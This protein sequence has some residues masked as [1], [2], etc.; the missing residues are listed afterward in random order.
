MKFEE[1]VTDEPPSLMI[2]NM[3]GNFQCSLWAC[4]TSGKIFT[5]FATPG[6]FQKFSNSEVSLERKFNKRPYYVLIS[7]QYSYINMRK[8]LVRLFLHKW[9]H[10]K[11]TP[12][13]TTFISIRD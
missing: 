4:A 5:R 11:R 6:N 8:S 12:G 10:F 1:T 3:A 13:K 9:S 7:S 2:E